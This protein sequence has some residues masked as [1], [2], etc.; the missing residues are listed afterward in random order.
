[1]GANSRTYKFALGDA[2]LE[3][4]RQG[5][6]EILLRDL[7][8][9]YA[10]RL[11]E[12]AARAPQAPRGTSIG[13][14]DFL[15]VAAAEREETHQL[16]RP[17][18]RL[19]DAAVKSMPAM[20]MRKFHNL[21]GGSEVPHRFYKVTGSPRRRSV[22]L[23]PQ[24]L[25]VAQSDQARGLRA[26]LDARWSI[27]ESSFAA[28]IGRAL[29]QEGVTVDWPTLQLTDKRRRRPVTGVAQAL[30]GFQH[31]RCLICDDT[32]DLA[33]PLA[34]DH[35]FPFALMQR[36]ASV[37]RWTGP[38]LDALWNLAPAH[39]ACNSTKSDRLPRNGELQRLTQRNEAIMGSPHPLKKTLQLALHT[40]PGSR[41]AARWADFLHEVQRCCI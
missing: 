31:G 1:M 6:T 38:D 12:H 4:A 37:G 22:T 21:G 14:T 28:G 39:E 36:Y 5:H 41:V 24:L 3:H 40:A 13:E 10:M 9:P 8:V 11:A 33:D 17:T 23:T 29:V 34:V 16:G 26:E 25:Q 27:V 15:G 7:A 32:L 20:V 19:L 35:V 18:D 2:L 30:I